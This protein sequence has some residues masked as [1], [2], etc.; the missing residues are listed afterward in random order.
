ML[1][2]QRGPLT[3]MLSFADIQD[4]LETQRG[5]VVPDHGG[6]GKQGQRASAALVGEKA[7]HGEWSHNP[8]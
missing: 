7:L 3:M 4:T 2:E 8:Q 5:T 1:T 6:R